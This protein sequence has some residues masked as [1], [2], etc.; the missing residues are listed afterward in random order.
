MQAIDSSGSSDAAA[1][2][3]VWD[4][5]CQL[6]T[7]SKI[8]DSQAGAADAANVAAVT[9][10]AAAAKDTPAGYTGVW[11]MPTP[12]SCTSEL[13]ATGT[14]SAADSVAAAG[15]GCTMQLLSLE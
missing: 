2:A 9:A 4:S 8:A 6:P 10:A 13:T 7:L 11:Q 1:A 5:A 3:G 15:W 12:D 14:G